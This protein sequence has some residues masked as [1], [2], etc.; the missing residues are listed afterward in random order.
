MGRP[1]WRTWRIKL[2]CSFPEIQTPGHCS[3]RR[4]PLPKPQDIV[5]SAAELDILE[6]GWPQDVVPAL[7][8]ALAFPAH[9]LALSQRPEASD[10]LV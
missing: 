7:L 2:F 9:G 3:H 10:P 1:T 8:P 4:R 6:R 5:V